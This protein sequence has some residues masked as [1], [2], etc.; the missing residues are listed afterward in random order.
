MFIHFPFK[1]LRLPRRVGT[2]NDA[3]NL[4]AITSEFCHGFGMYFIQ[5]LNGFIDQVITAHKQ[6]E[7][8][9]ISNS[10][11]EKVLKQK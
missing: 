5:F 1:I 7:K 6:I 11:Y 9:V 10:E 2:D 4:N 3:T 8:W